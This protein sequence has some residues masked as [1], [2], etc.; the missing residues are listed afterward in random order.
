MLLEGGLLPIRHIIIM[1]RINYVHTLL[2]MENSSLAKQVFQEQL[3]NPNKNDFSN[4][5]QQNLIEFDIKL[6]FEEIEKISKNRFKKIVRE[7]CYRTA[8]RYLIEEKNKLS[9]GNNLVYTSLKTQNY[10][11]PG[12]GLNTQDIKQIYSIRTRNLFLKTN[13]PGM[14]FDDKCVNVNCQEKDTEFHLFYSDCFNEGNPIM[15]QNI[16]FNQIFSNNVFEQ[17]VIK[18]ILIERYQKR[19]KTLSSSGRSR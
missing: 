12:T 11:K 17:K 3:R 15:Q 2:N 9:K 4:Q 6:T 5:I 16:E 13:F 7:A 19:L 10:L 1:R 18:D 14:Y 8:Y